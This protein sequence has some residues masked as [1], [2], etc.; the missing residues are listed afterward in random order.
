M[1]QTENRTKTEKVILVGTAL[2][3]SRKSDTDYMLDELSRLTETAGGKE[4]A[5]FVQ[6]R[7][8]PDS[9]YFVGKGLVE[10][11]H[12]AAEEHDAD[13]VVFDD[14]L[15]PNQLRNLSD[16]IGTKVIDRPMLI[17]DIFALHAR[18]AESRLQVELA[19]ME[20]LLP[21]LA[22][23][24]AHFN[25][26]RGGIGTKGPGE[27]QLEVDRRQVR[28]RISVLK[29]KL[30]KISTQRETQRKSRGKFYRVALVGYTNAGKSTLFNRLTKATVTE[31]NQLFST[32]DS[33][34]RVMATEYPQK[35][36][37][38][39]TV[40]FIEKLPHQLVASFKSTLEEVNQA[41]L[42]LLVV[43]CTDPYKERKIEVVRSVLS[44]I[45]AGDISNLLVYNKID[46]L[47]NGYPLTADQNGIIPVSAL[48]AVGLN[49]LR[50]EIV[51]RLN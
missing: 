1:Y 41:N 37:F 36:V 31:A 24:W 9:A 50:A 18:T 38:T 3:K 23:L 14:P 20:Y 34:S 42:V 22:G 5:R 13:M 51:A 30:G 26:Q 46:L 33:T 11:I 4:I 45:G 43:D 7:D 17:L 29:R 47:D 25:R 35:V 21:R 27:T 12:E 28:T 10:S 16:A 32:L 6:R 39:D 19:Q 8:H 49:R 2:G 15:A 44:E 40:G 48:R